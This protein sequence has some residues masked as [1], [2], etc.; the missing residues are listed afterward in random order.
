MEKET[1]LPKNIRQIGDIQGR[2]RICIEDYVMTYIRKK[3]P[4]EEQGYL[5]VLLGERKET[6]DMVYVFVRG[7]LEL[8][9][10]SQDEEKEHEQKSRL[11]ETWARER[12]ENFP[13]WDVQG[14]CIIGAY[15]TRKLEML[16]EILPESGQM[17][18]H[19]QEQ[20]ETLFWKESEQYRR[21]KG[22]FVFYEQNRKMQE[23][24]AEVF[25]D[26]SVEKESLPDRAIKSFREKV[27]EKNEKKTGSLLKLASSFFV[28]TVLI[29]GAIVV[30]RIDEIRNVRNTALS[31]LEALSNQTQQEGERL[32]ASNYSAAEQGNGEAA[33]ANMKGA[34]DLQTA[35]NKAGTGGQQNMM[36]A[37]SQASAGELQS[38]TTTG[39]ADSLQ[40]IANTDGAGS[41]QNAANTDGAGSL[42]NAANTDNAGSLQNA[43]NADNAG[44]LQS[45]ANTDTTDSLQNTTNTDTTDSLQNTTNTGSTDG[46]QGTA[47]TDSTDG[48]QS[49]AD[50]GAADSQQNASDTGASESEASEAASRAIRASYVIK[51]G[52]TLANICSKY[53]GSTDKMEEICAANH[54]ADANMIMPGQ[55][56][57][58]P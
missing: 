21:I 31:E 23:Y 7:I 54:I 43:A 1:V 37:A 57:V 11:K 8:S 50:T 15:P 2:E 4:Q 52:D 36:D 48:Q 39:T 10:E 20:E 45:T 30:N 58:L 51:V 16:S 17:I 33:A 56:I 22:Y 28:V 13:G 14:C 24:L 35:A 25:R 40:S 46:L 38:T 19:L 41:L 47:N 49:T 9:F 5:G 3:E 26:D 29:I 12:A 18:Y 27:K 44:S 32:K 6:E 34:D 53:Y 55:K 42:Q